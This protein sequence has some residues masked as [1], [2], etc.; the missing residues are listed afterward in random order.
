MGMTR[1]E[2]IERVTAEL[3]AGGWSS[4][5]DFVDDH[6]TKKEL[7]AM[8]DEDEDWVDLNDGD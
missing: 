8:D 1:D 7:N 5:Y 2:K 3:A 4:I 6:I